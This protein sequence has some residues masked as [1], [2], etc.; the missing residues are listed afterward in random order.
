VVNGEFESGLDGWSLSAS[1]GI[2]PSVV[3]EPVHTGR[4]ALALGVTPPVAAERTPQPAS[5][6]GVTQT[7]AL[8]DSWQPILSFWYYPLTTDG[9]DVFNVTLTVVPQTISPTLPVTTTLVFTP[10][11]EAAGWRHLWYHILEPDVT[12]TGTVTIHFDLWEDGDDAAT[13]VYLDEVS[14]GATP[15]GPQRLYVPLSLKQR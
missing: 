15:G 10:D 1:Q 6:V 2:S 4:H 13:I 5:T 11:L 3:T 12:L 14:L 9:D 7:V 8:T